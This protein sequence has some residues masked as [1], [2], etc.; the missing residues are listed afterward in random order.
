MNGKQGTNPYDKEDFNAYKS[1]FHRGTGTENGQTLPVTNQQPAAVIPVNIPSP[2]VTPSPVVYQE[3]V[4]KA[5]VYQAPVQ[6]IPVQKVPVPKA[7]VQQPPVA[8]PPVESSS[9]CEDTAINC[10]DI[11]FL[12]A[13]DVTV[14]EK[15]CRKSCNGCVK[16]M[17][18]TVPIQTVPVQ[19]V[20]VQT[21]PPVPIRAEMPRLASIPV[22]NSQIP[23]Y[24]VDMANAN[25][26]VQNPV[27]VSVPLQTVPLQ[28]VP[29]QPVPVQTV[30]V[31]PVPVQTV[32]IQPVQLTL[33]PTTA[34]PLA[35]LL[36]PTPT[37]YRYI[38]ATTVKPVAKPA[39][40]CVDQA[41]ECSL[42]TLDMCAQPFMGNMVRKCPKTCGTCGGAAPPAPSNE[43]VAS[44]VAPAP[45]SA[46]VCAD[47]TVINIDVNINYFTMNYE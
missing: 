3:P 31:R 10:Q 30:P 12:C 34:Q 1:L 26:P 21:V 38:P 18:H 46:P 32:P 16:D 17:A 33:A 24:I 14:R 25:L 36:K 29:V 4:Y 6:K 42:I 47:R 37:G 13:H 45:T 9:E 19:P 2:P 40:P 8:G 11:I 22:I 35:P 43:R 15:Y 20:P 7:P 41:T 23:S 27:A 5:P 39:A 28:P 44:I